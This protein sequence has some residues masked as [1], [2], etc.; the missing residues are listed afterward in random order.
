MSTTFR[1]AA[2]A[3]A[4]C[5]V[6]LT[7]QQ[8]AAQVSVG[9]SDSQET[10]VYDLNDSEF[11]SDGTSQP[12]EVDSVS[13]AANFGE[14]HQLAVFSNASPV[15][16]S[17][18]LNW[19]P[20]TGDWLRN[21]QTGVFATEENIVIT[22]GGQ[23]T[24]YETCGFYSGV[25]ALGTISDLDE[26]S[27]EGGYSVDAFAAFP[28]MQNGCHEHYVKGGVFY[29]QQGEMHQVGATAGALL[30]A[31]CCRPLTIDAA[32]GFGGGR[33]PFGP[34]VVQAVEH[35]YQLRVGTFLSPTVQ[36]GVSTYYADWENAFPDD[37]DWGIGGFANVQLTNFI[38]QLDLTAGEDEMSGYVN[39]VY[40]PGALVQCCCCDVVRGQGPPPVDGQS[41]MKSPVHRNLA[42]RTR[43]RNAGGVGGVA[44][45]SSV[46]VFS[47]AG[48]QTQD[49][50]GNGFADPGDLF[51]VD[52]SFTAGP[53]GATGVSFGNNTTVIGPGAQVGGV[54]A[55][56]GDLMPGETRTTDRNS[57]A[58]IRI[59]A[60][61]NPGD[62][63]FL[64]YDVTADGQ[65]RRFRTGPYIVGQI[66]NGTAAT[67]T[68]Q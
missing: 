46:A 24:V 9:L 60:T 53:S 3:V 1:T 55:T 5:W 28:I 37:D 32:V 62:Q 8:A 65:T 64:E 10:G 19:S 33:E 66:G 67:S 36:A 7:I 23:A 61:A 22:A 13:Y 38:V 17:A 35:D 2:G 31:D 51:E 18:G 47:P 43:T 40:T 29:D 11:N 25:R 58:C 50:N 6:L 20:A 21:F 41:W 57:D 52:F 16:S 4:I 45:T 56:V 14:N 49:N 15:G 48:A 44:M 34:T 54:G 39:F 30:F 68:A 59:D 12:G 26:S 42:I 27:I 63:I